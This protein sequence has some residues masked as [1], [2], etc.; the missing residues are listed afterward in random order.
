MTACLPFS[1]YV[2][3]VE[4]E[5]EP[6]VYIK[7]YSNC[8]PYFSEKIRK[9]VLEKEEKKIALEK[10]ND[11]DPF[12]FIQECGEKYERTKSPHGQ[13]SLVK[14][15]IHDFPLYLN[16]LNQS[17]LSME[18]KF[19]NDN[20][21]LNLDYYIYMPNFRA[22]NLLGSNQLSQEEF[23]KFYE[24]EM[25][26]DE[27]NVIRP[28]IFDIERRYKKYKGL[29][30]EA[31]NESPI[32]WDYEISSSSGFLKCRVDE[33]NQ[34]NVI[35]QTTFSL[36]IQSAI[37]IIDKCVDLF[38]SNKYEIVVIEN[39]NGGGKVD[40]SIYLKQLLQVNIQS[41]GP[42]VAYKPNDMTEL[43]YKARPL[44]FTN[45]ETCKPYYDFND[46]LNGETDD[47]SYDDK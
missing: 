12:D 22:M 46:F 8:A 45:I 31:E 39:A 15:L 17:E 9:R 43:F 13:F 20:E 35:L 36:D 7:Y 29:L 5:T 34:L 4:N 37:N 24:N 6:K 28:N 47:Y 32:K 19:E 41:R 3:K 18:F 16:P 10:I 30:L 25:L 42:Y 23:D 21:T 27:D 1:F 33:K 11:K 38:H 44:M 40:I 26:K 2:D 14:T